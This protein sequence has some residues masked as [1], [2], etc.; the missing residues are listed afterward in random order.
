MRYIKYRARPRPGVGGSISNPMTNQTLGYNSNNIISDEQVDLI[1]GSV[2][3]RAVDDTISDEQVDRVLGPV[4]DRLRGGEFYQPHPK[5]NLF[6]RRVTR[7]TAVVGLAAVVTFAILVHTPAESTTDNR[8]LFEIPKPAIPLSGVGA[9]LSNY[10]F[11][12][13]PGTSIGGIELMLI[14]EGGEDTYYEA[15]VLGCRSIP[16]GIYR[17]VAILPTDEYADSSVEAGKLIVGERRIELIL[18]EDFEIFFERQLR[19]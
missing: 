2:L 10:G 7:L 5:P 18:N 17:V 12:S 1:L 15:D 9:L 13:T 4:L 8:M 19:C 3:N 16:A 11:Y 6:L 14:K